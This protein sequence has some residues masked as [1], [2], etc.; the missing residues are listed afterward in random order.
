MINKLKIIKR[1]LFLTM[2]RRGLLLVWLW[3]WV[4][5]LFINWLAGLP[6]LFTVFSHFIVWYL[7]TEFKIK[8]QREEIDEDHKVISGMIKEL[9][10]ELFNRK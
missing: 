10:N 3:L 4:W 6:L 8:P 5:S 7:V 1:I 2:V 9:K